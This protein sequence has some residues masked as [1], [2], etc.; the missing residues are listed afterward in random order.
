MPLLCRRGS[1][2]FRALHTDAGPGAVSTGTRLPQLGA[3]PLWHG[4]R[5]MSYTHR[6]DNH[7]HHNHHL[8]S[9]FG[10]S[11]FGSSAHASLSVA[12][13]FVE[14]WFGMVPPSC[15]LIVPFGLSQ[16]APSVVNSMVFE[17]YIIDS[18]GICQAAKPCSLGGSGGVSNTSYDNGCGDVLPP[19]AGPSVAHCLLLHMMNMLIEVTWSFPGSSLVCG[20][21]STP[22]HVR[23]ALCPPWFSATFGFCCDAVE[24][25]WTVRSFRL[26]SVCRV[27][28]L[29]L[30]SC[31]IRR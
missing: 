25:S 11:H 29:P 9:H 22:V 24:S 6:L 27:L 30:V 4:T 31:C 13:V 8:R 17:T 23:V 28:E 1:S 26:S 2:F 19:S 21:G 14:S 12:Q 7:H 16:P 10:S 5:H 18:S 3:R 20:R 15:V